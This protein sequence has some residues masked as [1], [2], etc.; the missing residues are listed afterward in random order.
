[1][2]TAQQEFRDICMGVLDRFSQ[3]PLPEIKPDLQLEAVFIEFRV[4]PHIEV[5]I[6]NAIIK[7][8]TMWSFTIVCGNANY[9]FISEMCSRIGRQIKIIKLSYEN[10]NINGYNNL[11]LT[12]D[13]WRLFKGNKILIYQEDSFIFKN[14][15]F[16]FLKFD[17]VGAPWTHLQ[18]YAVV[19]NGGFSL[20]SKNVMISILQNINPLNVPKHP[21][22]INDMKRR[23]MDRI[24]EDIFFSKSMSLHGVGNLATFRDALRFSA[25]YVA[26]KDPFGGH[27]FW[28]GIKNWKYHL[29][30]NIMNMIQQPHLQL[31]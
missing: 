25:E 27:K 29:V 14:N 3:I 26:S 31:F 8:G 4:L 20:R 28:F 11:L 12:I 13:F 10:L 15:Y 9:P 7:L 23:Q 22:I 18:N 2:N 1:M 16:D 6:R 30:N 24:P 17:Y 21:K 5:I 19:G